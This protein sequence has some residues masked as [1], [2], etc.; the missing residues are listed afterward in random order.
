MGIVFLQGLL[1]SSQIF[2][3]GVAELVD[4]PD[5]K[6][7]SFG[8]SVQVRPPVPSYDYRQRRRGLSVR[9]SSI[10]TKLLNKAGD[11]ARAALPRPVNVISLR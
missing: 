5:S 2:D 6:S 4:A 3:A 10:R 8:V 7:G 11:V 9:K 1:Y